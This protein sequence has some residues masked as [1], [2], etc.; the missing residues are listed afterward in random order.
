MAEPRFVLHGQ[1][2]IFDTQNP[3]AMQVKAD[4]TP[5]ARAL[6]D[7][8]NTLHSALQELYTNY[9]SMMSSEF[10]FPG[11]PWTPERDNDVV[12]M[13][14]RDALASAANV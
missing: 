12:A 5:E 7:T 9:C 11:R 6:I 8:L 2:I 4:S 14:A 3:R 13:A 1:R 10:D